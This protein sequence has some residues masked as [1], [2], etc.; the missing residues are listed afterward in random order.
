MDT[1]ITNIKA[2]LVADRDGGGTLNYM[3]E[4]SIQKV[5]PK[6]LPPLRNDQLPFVGIAPLTSPEIWITSGKR[7]VTHTVELYCVRQYTIQED[8]VER[9]LEFVTD[10]L[11]VVR[12]ER[13]SSYIDAPA[14]PNVIDYSTA[15]YGDNIYII[16]ATIQ[17][18]CRR[19]F[20]STLP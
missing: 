8:S 16:V 13:F 17:L 14:T 11:S 10:V 5:A 2:V 9:F 1:L 18:E 12:N 19:T 6:A 7:E 4:Q 3:P 20:L 15:P